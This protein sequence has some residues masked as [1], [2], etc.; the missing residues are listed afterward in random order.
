LNLSNSIQS[1]D[2]VNNAVTAAKVNTNVFDQLTITGGN[3]SAAA[4]QN[5]PAWVTTEV[6]GQSFSANTTYAIRRAIVQNGETAGR[7]YAA[8]IDT[9]TYDEF[10]VIGLF[11][12]PTSVSAGNSI[13]VVRK[14]LLTLGSSDT[15]FATND[16][17]KPFFLQAAGAWSNTAPSTTGQA[18]TRLGIVKSTNVV[19]VDAVPVGVN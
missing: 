7:V 3:G 13:T 12:N 11:N 17:G 19:D 4:V 16:Q 2:L 6:A 15:A 18:I 9:S 14:G 10:Y 8:D 5:A 1:T